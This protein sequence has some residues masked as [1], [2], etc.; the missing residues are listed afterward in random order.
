MSL[1]IAAGVSGAYTF[2]DGPGVEILRGS[3]REGG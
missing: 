1:V 3:G 2:V